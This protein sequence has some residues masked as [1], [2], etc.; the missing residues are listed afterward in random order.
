M[1]Y[2]LYAF[3]VL[4]C[5]IGGLHLAIRDIIE[6]KIS[7][8]AVL[9]YL[10]IQ[11]IW[12]GV[13]IAFRVLEPSVLLTA[14]IFMTTAYICQFILYCLSRGALGYGDVTAICVCALL[15][16]PASMNNVD[17]L[18]IWWLLMSILGL[19]HIAYVLKIRK[20]R[21]IAFVPAEYISAVLTVAALIF[22][23]SL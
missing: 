19:L 14:L 13:F 7:R 8:L 21:T 5:L 11:L 3:Y 15:F 6:R 18:I 9:C 20:G 17:W 22:T 2:L 23:Q 10:I 4:P 1:D 16:A 12:F